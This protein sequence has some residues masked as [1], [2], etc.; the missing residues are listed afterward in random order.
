MLCKLQK[1]W[2]AGVGLLLCALIIKVIIEKISL[3]PSKKIKKGKMDI[4]KYKTFDADD[5]EVINCMFSSE[6]YVGTGNKHNSTSRIITTT[7]KV[8]LNVNGQRK[9]AYSKEFYNAGTR[10]KVLTKSSSKFASM[11]EVEE[12]INP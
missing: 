11:V 9:T 12:E 6:S 3:C 7:Y 1:S 5:A 10:V 8:L 2:G 4:S